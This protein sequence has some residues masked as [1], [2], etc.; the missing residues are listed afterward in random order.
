M[1]MDKT[2]H[3]GVELALIESSACVVGGRRMPLIFLVFYAPF[4]AE[5]IVMVSTNTSNVTGDIAGA[6][7]SDRG[8]IAE[9]T[10]SSVAPLSGYS[11]ISSMPGHSHRFWPS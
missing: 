5:V 2:G 4:V 8:F 7:R 10:T 9:E 11:S 3:F 1:S 6:T